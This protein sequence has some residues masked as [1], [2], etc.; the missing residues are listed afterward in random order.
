MLGQLQKILQ[1][2]S[3]LGT[4]R[5]VALFATGVVVFLITGLAG[6]YLSRP[7]FELL[8][9]GLDRTDVSRIGEVLKDANIN[10]DISADGTTVSVHYG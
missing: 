7:Q 10:F 1:N 2:L 9:S 4:K 3:A 8:Y 6:Y 5:L